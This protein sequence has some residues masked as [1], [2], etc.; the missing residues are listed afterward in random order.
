MLWRC[1]VTA[2]G[3]YWAVVYVSRFTVD[4]GV[5]VHGPQT[6]LRWTES[7]LLPL[8]VVHVHWVQVRAADEE[9][10]L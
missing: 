7:T 6:G 8:G 2:M 9:E 3:L 5:L 4:L 10:I 1:H